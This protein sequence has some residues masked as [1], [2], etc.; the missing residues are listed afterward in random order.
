VSVAEASP[1]ASCSDV[2]RARGVQRGSCDVLALGSGRVNAFCGPAT[3]AA[4]GVRGANDQW[5]ILIDSID[6]GW[7]DDVS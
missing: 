2:H 5:A 1:R 6:A 3:R 4:D 7:F